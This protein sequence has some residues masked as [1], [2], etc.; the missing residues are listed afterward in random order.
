VRVLLGPSLFEIS[1]RSR[2][3]HRAVFGVQMVCLG[4]ASIKRWDLQRINMTTL[5]SGQCVVRR[6]VNFTAIGKGWKTLRMLHIVVLDGDNSAGGN[7]DGV[8][9][10]MQIVKVG[11]GWR[12]CR[13]LSFIC[14]VIQIRCNKTIMI[15]AGKSTLAGYWIEDQWR[16][17]HT[18]S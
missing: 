8:L 3:V 17:F 4:K 18:V 6:K 10:D 15:T 7:L 5:Y 13:P 16:I 1:Q 9:R 14:W 12:S 2:S 11:M